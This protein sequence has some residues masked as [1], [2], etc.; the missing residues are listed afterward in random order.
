MKPCWKG[1]SGEAVPNVRA[2]EEKTWLGSQGVDTQAHLGLCFGRKQVLNKKSV[3]LASSFQNRNPRG[4]R[5]TSNWEANINIGPQTL[6]LLSAESN[7]K[8]PCWDIL[9]DC[10]SVCASPRSPGSIFTVSRGRDSVLGV[11]PAS[12]TGPPVSEHRP[13][14]HILPSDFHS[15]LASVATTWRHNLNSKVTFKISLRSFSMGLCLR[16]HPWSDSS[17]SLSCFPPHPHP[18]AWNTP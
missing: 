12:T 1:F 4:I 7:V 18:F 2:R 16:S 3:P 10:V 15:S 5:E 14:R 8:S 9:A 6:I 17:S 13:P 11:F